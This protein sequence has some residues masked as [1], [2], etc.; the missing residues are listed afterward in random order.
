MIPGGH[1]SGGVEPYRELMAR[2]AVTG[3]IRQPR[4]EWGLAIAAYLYLGGLG[5][6]AF[7]VGVVLDW[8]GFGLPAVYATPFAS[9]TWDWSKTL[10][11]AAP[12]VAA[13][14][15]SLLIFDLGRNWYLFFTAGRNPRTS[16]MARGFSILL[17]F[18]LTACLVGAVSLFAPEWRSS[19]LAFW[20]VVE[21]LALAAALGTAGYT[22]ILLRSMKYVPAWNISLLPLLFSASALSTGSMAVLLAAVI[23][24]A[25]GV[26]AAAVEMV[27]RSL[28]AFELVLI[29][30]EAVLLGLYVRSL[31]GGNLEAQLSARKLISGEWRY[32]FWIGV[33]GC[34]LVIPFVLDLVNLAFGSG[35]LAVVTACS[36]L[37][38]GFILRL[39][40]LGIGVR[41]RAPLYRLGEWRGQHALGL[42]R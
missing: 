20:R 16:W 11:L 19:G 40:V 41:E 42:S 36:V 4:D 26:E 22:G 14:G 3:E 17:A 13:A 29:A 33:V 1:A 31:V 6:G 10:M 21:A 24:G 30:V 7:A 5:A 28:E 2:V 12:L 18:I 27:V 15:A 34:A 8:L 9:W 32:P 38:G 25:F 39:G 37:V 35:A 23:A